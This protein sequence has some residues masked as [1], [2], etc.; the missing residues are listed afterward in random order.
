MLVLFEFGVEP[1]QSV[2][3]AQSSLIM[4]GDSCTINKRDGPPHPNDVSR[5]C[6]K[7]NHWGVPFG[8]DPIN[9]SSLLRTFFSPLYFSTLFVLCF[10]LC[11]YDRALINDRVCKFIAFNCVSFFLICIVCP[12]S[13]VS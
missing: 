8:T 12:A 1:K 5:P 4:I 10:T 3:C 2:G 13:T 6:G 11:D 7:W 9:G